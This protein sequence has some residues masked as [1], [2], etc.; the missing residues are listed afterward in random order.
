MYAM[1][2]ITVILEL[3]FPQSTSPLLQLYILLC[4][5]CFL[6]TPQHIQDTKLLLF[7]L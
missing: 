3:V 2:I 4:I 7:I 5:M 6:F 1:L